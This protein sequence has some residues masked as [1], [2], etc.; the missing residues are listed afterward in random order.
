VLIQHKHCEEANTKF[1]LVIQIKRR[2]TGQQKQTIPPPPT[3]QLQY[4]NLNL[5]DNKK[6]EEALQTREI[7]IKGGE[8]LLHV[9]V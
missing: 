9:N 6:E 5:T 1:I 4:A 8:H 7:L 2:V 3:L